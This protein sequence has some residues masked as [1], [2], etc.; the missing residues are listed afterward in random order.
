M[1]HL[2]VGIDIG[3]TYT[4]IGL[5]SREGEC[6]AQER[7]RTQNFRVLEEYLEKVAACI[8]TLR[9]QMVSDFS[10]DGVGIGAP[11][12]NYQN[13]TVFNPGNLPWKGSTELA[14]LLSEKLNYPTKIINDGNAAVLGELHFGSGRNMRDF[15]VLTLGTGLGS[16]I[17]AN[18]QLVHGHTGYAARMGHFSVEDDGWE[19]V[20]GAKG[21][22]EAYVSATGLKRSVLYMQ[23]KYNYESRFR[24]IAY[25]NLRGE[26]I[27]AAALEGDKIAL[28]AFDFVGEKLGKFMCK[29][30][31]ALE[32][33][34]IILSGG[35]VKAGDLLLSP[36]KEY[37]KKHSID[38]FKG[39]V[40][41][42]LSALGDKSASIIGAASLVWHK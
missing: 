3:G 25:H 33:E 40:K 7:F 19:T 42:K 12:V 35:L 36:T 2:A 16:G 28:A 11:D 18:G 22:I 15:V 38:L 31:T 10:I 27:M 5:V 8:E 21:G 24:D 41:I 9:N 4:K 1:R 30:A 29:L 6:L 32:P 26:E 17:V 23:A 39:K 34:A 37:F 14:R 13:Q 20:L